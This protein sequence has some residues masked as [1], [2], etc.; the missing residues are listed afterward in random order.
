MS[1]DDRIKVEVAVKYKLFTLVNSTKKHLKD[2]DKMQLQK[3]INKMLRKLHKIAEELEE[4][5]YRR[6]SEFIM[7]NTRFM[8][9]F[10]ELALEGIQVLYTTNRIERLMGEVSKRCK[11]KWMH[12][13]TQGLKDIFTIVFIRYTNEPL[14]ENFKKA[15]IHNETIQ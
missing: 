3:R 2:K 10:A 1:K 8:V 6:A 5:S 4:D 15:Y 12:W 13:S 11:H 7:K 14:Y 9:T